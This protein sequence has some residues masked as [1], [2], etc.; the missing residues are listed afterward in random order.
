MSDARV[1]RA[2]PEEA[3]EVARLLIAFR[4]W[5]GRDWPGD[6]DY[7]DS[8]RRLIAREDTEFLLGAP[9]QG[10][11]AA[12]VTQLRFRWSV[13]WSAEDCALE[14]LYVADEAR[15]SG[16]GR[17]LVQASLDRAGERGCRRVELDVNTANAPALA[18]YRSFG[19][20]TGKGEGD[21]DLLMRLRL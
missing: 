6:E 16:L 21:E 7:R 17:T 14:D 20:S 12:G 10:A 1:W 4:D 11:R 19:F 18:L 8:V 5:W 9:S 3:D 2:T 15:G 13:W